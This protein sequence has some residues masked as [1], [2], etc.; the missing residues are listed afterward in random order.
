MGK[1]TFS[2]AWELS[3]SGVVS[4][5]TFWTQNDIKDTARLSR[6]LIYDW[7]KFNSFEFNEGGNHV[8]MKEKFLPV[9]KKK[10]ETEKDENIIIINEKLLRMGP[11]DGTGIK[12]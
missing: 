6:V 5:K 9:T 2:R 1:L 7:I 12:D 3:F 10:T 4:N 11:V 8:N